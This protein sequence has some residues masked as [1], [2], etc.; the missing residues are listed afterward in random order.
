MITWF[1]DSL[2]LFK[3]ISFI[4]S[5]LFFV[6]TMR[7]MIKMQYFESATKYG[8]NFL[9]K[10]S[11]TNQVMEKFWKQIL[12]RVTSHNP[13]EWKKAILDADRIFDESLRIIGSKGKTV[14]E[15]IE[16]A[17]RSITGSLQDLTLLRNEVLHTIQQE[18]GFVSRE[19]TK[20]I[21][22]EYRSVLRQMG[23]L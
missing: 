1:L 12:K 8:F 14:T 18:Q 9:R 20:E 22:R 11:S 10:V 23:M 13:E 19:K 3:T 15:R 4:V 17:D 6:L 16:S 21:L 7:L 2:W 5:V